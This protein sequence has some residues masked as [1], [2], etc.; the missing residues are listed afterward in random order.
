MQA[1]Y[2][3]KHAELCRALGSGAFDEAFR[4]IYSFFRSEENTDSYS[5]QALTVVRELLED[6]DSEELGRVRIRM[7]ASGDKMLLTLV[8]FIL[9]LKSGGREDCAEILAEKCFGE[10]SRFAGSMQEYADE[11][12]LSKATEM[13]G[14]RIREA[15]KLLSWYFEDL[16]ET[17][18]FRA[19]EVLN[20]RMTRIFLFEDRGLLAGDMRRAAEA[21]ILGGSDVRGRSLCEE[22]IEAFG[23]D[24]GDEE[25]HR[26]LAFARG[27]VG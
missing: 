13:A 17:E 20:L 25:I 11:E 14:R 8:Q 18:S 9:A 1:D 16:G 19:C 23:E 5:I 15:M 27:V 24:S 4:L 7:R 26:A 6:G 12:G 3:G 2:K 21:E 22:I 10:L